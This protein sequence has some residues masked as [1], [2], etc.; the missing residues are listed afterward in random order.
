MTPKPTNLRDQLKRDEGVVLH[1][2]Q[3]SLGFWTIGSGILIDARRGGGIA[4]A[5]NDYLLDNR[6]SAKTAEL[7]RAIP[8]MAQVDSVRRGAFLNMAF[9]LGVSGL[10]G[11]HATLAAAQSGDWTTCAAH[12]RDSLWHK[13]TGVRAERLAKQIET[14]EWQ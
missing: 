9:N 7:F 5:E 12:M 14:G 6:I 3:D 8:W 11:F 2:Y 4:E 10:Q 13:Q 1:A